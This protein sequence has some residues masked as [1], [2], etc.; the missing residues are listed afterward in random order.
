VVVAKLNGQDVIIAGAGPG[1][2]PLVNVFDAS[3]NMISSFMTF[4]P[5]FHGGIYVAAGD[6]HGDGGLEIVVGAGAQPDAVPVVAVYEV[7]GN[8]LG[9]FMAFDTSFKGGVRIALADPF[10]LGRKDIVAAAGPG[11]S[12]LVGVWDGL[13]LTL[14]EPMFFAFPKDFSG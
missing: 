7:D 2:V 4:N 8:V 11:G 5:V 12:P 13:S 9:G 10:G 3:G 14:A 6:L 1:G